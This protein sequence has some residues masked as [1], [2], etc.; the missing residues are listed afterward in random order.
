MFLIKFFFANQIIKD[1]ENENLLTNIKFNQQDFEFLL[2]QI[3]YQYF[4][5]GLK[6]ENYIFTD[7][8]ISNFLYIKLINKIFPKAKFV[9]CYRNPVA[10]IIGILRSFLPNI[11]WSHDLDKIFSICDLYFGELNN[12]KNDKSVNFYYLSLEELTSNPTLVSQNLYKY[13]ELKWT[14]KCLDYNKNEISFKTASN[15]QVR[16]KI[17]KHNLNY[18]KEFLKLFK[19]L[20]YDYTWLR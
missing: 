17:Q 8:S 13:L 18:T 11:F 10:N 14:A 19:E 12:I 7:K 5:Q 15:L 20:G 1:Y 4:S 16:E 9:Y 6:K 2:K 3:N